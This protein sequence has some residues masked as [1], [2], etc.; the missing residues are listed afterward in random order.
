MH[1]EGLTLPDPKPGKDVV[2]TEVV[3]D[4]IARAELGKKRYGTYLETHNGRSALMDAY[5]E[6][7]DYLKQLLMEVE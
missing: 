7:L 3:K 4:V 1:K 5:E 2:W 6:A